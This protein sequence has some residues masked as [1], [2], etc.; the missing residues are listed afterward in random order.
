MSSAKYLITAKSGNVKTGPIMVTTSPRKTCPNACPF[1]KDNDGGCYAEG[2]P[3][4]EMWRGLDRTEPG[5]AFK[6]GRSQVTV[7]S[8]AEL[9][10]AI[11]S[12]AD[13]ALWR[14]NQAGDLAGEADTIDVKALGEIVAA[15]TGKRGFTYTHK[16]MTSEANRNAVHSANALGFT[17]NLSGNSLAHA[18]ELADLNIGPVVCVV[19]VDQTSNTVTPKGRK[20]VICP[21][22]QRDDVSCATCKL[23]SRQREAIVAF[24]AH[25][26][27]KRKAS[28]IA[29][30]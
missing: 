1:R 10:E 23:C 18:D 11:E 5:E 24:P 13:G 27:S 29:S 17:V 20:V 12:L 6:N 28:V 21:A 2:G 3:L 16:P 4:A 26:A 25:G 19:P 15:N 9:L 8:H 22:T 7:K 14:H 30:R